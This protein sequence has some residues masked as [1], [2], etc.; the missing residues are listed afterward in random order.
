MCH[1]YCINMVQTARI[2]MKNYLVAGLFLPSLIVG[3][4]RENAS[5]KTLYQKFSGE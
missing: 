5:T 3:C 2:D 1:C 4:G